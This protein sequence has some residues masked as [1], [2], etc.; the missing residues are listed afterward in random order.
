MNL[1]GKF[2]T[3]KNALKTVLIS[4]VDAYEIV[5]SKLELENEKTTR[6]NYYLKP[7]YDCLMELNIK[8]NVKNKSEEIVL[9]ELKEKVVETL[10]YNNFMKD[11]INITQKF[12]GKNALKVIP[13]L[14]QTKVLFY[15]IEINDK[16]VDKVC[17]VKSTID[18]LKKWGIYQL[19]EKYVEF[20]LVATNKESHKKLLEMLCQNYATDFTIK[21]ETIKQVALDCEEK[22]REKLYKCF[23]KIFKKEI[24]SNVHKVYQ[25]FLKRIA[26]INIY[27][28][29]SKDLPNIEKYIT[30]KWL[31]EEFNYNFIVKDPSEFDFIFELEFKNLDE[32]R[33]TKMKNLEKILSNFWK[34]QEIK[35]NK[36]L[37]SKDIKDCK[38]FLYQYDPILDIFKAKI[39][40]QNVEEVF[41]INKEFYQ[42]DIDSILNKI[43]KE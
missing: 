10:A 21:F 22:D 27:K 28:E 14:Y 38:I 42:N 9:K 33:K 36:Y 40:K 4:N 5:T 32:E 43:I 18:L 15:M 34:Q 20:Y 7:C 37:L 30:L 23:N 26:Y 39:R 35:Y 1:N 2:I 11:A 19:N 16:V 17:K 8:L 24:I 13:M 12:I 31:Y 25:F 29:L 41:N 6:Y 3:L